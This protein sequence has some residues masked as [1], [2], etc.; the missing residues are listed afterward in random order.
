MEYVDISWFGQRILSG[1][2]FRILFFSSPK[3]TDNSTA[4]HG[5]VNVDELSNVDEL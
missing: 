4:S 5:M 3:S 1:M 2:A